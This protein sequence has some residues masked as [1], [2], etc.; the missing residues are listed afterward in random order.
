MILP[1]VPIL[2]FK[3]LFWALALAVFLRELAAAWRPTPALARHFGAALLLGVVV[4]AKFVYCV[5]YPGVTLAALAGDTRS[6]LIL[7]GAGAAPGALLGAVLALRLAQRSMTHARAA[8]AFD[9]D[10]LV[11]PAAWAL[12]ILDVG[13]LFWALS[14]PGFG[15]YTTVSWGMD[16]GD[17]I[18]RHPVMLYEAAFLLVAAWLHGRLDTGLFRAGERA[19]LFIA[20]YC[21]VR[22]LTDYLR[23]PFG[24]PFITEMMH[25]YPWIYFR[26]MTGEQWV[27]LLVLLGLLP[28]W[29]SLS[30]RLL[31][32]ARR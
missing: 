14:E 25:P 32:A 3:F 16:F 12:A 20:A 10:L 8:L 18:P 7:A 28:A 19:M 13:S 9:L 29:F 4:G 2:A 21:G 17:G 27:C 15:V 23:P 1:A 31:G 22:V 30:L 11:Q 26:L 5:S 6:L 24:M